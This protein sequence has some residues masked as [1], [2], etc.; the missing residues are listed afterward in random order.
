MVTVRG[1]R[2]VMLWIGMSVDPFENG[3]TYVR[4]DVKRS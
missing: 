2:K 4:Y 3:T 1:M